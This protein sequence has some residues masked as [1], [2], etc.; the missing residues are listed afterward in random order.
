MPDG[1]T[2]GGAIFLEL[3][4]EQ[5]VLGAD[6]PPAIP[7]GEPTLWRR[8]PRWIADFFLSALDSRQSRP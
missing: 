4:D 2:N 8:L 5:P 7:A 6:T 1:E 3:P